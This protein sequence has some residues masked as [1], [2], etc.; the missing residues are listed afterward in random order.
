MKEDFI[1]PILTALFL[2]GWLSSIPLAFKFGDKLDVV[3]SLFVPF[4]GIF[5]A[6]FS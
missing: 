1:E 4:Y 2:I 3:L 6:M 5:V